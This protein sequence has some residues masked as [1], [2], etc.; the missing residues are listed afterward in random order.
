MENGN[1]VPRI[2]EIWPTSVSGERRPN[3]SRDGGREV[4]NQNSE[5]RQC[6]DDTRIGR[7]Q[8]ARQ[9]VSGPNHSMIATRG[10]IAPGG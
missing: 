8:D 2:G 3:L 9:N 4:R 10:L 6:C 1:T 5:I 7:T